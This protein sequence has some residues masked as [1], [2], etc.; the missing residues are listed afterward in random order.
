MMYTYWKWDKAI[1]KEYCELI[2][3]N[4]DWAQ[5]KSARIHFD[6]SIEDESI[7]KTKIVWEHNLSVVGCIADRYI[8]AANVAA[9]WNYDLEK[10]LN[11][12][13]I[14]EYDSGGF[15]DWHSDGPIIHEMP[16]KLSFSLLLS[17]PKDFE[18]GVFELKNIKE[19]LIMEQG[20]V[21]VF[22][23]SYPHRVTPVTSGSR[24]SAVAWMHGP[25]FK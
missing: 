8:R 12:I 19:P 20:S 2:V 22:I 3:K 4:A 1:S 18:G 23:S 17:D 13:Q 24:Y 6:N 16:R 11:K 5:K 9:G 15:Y 14:G 10:N 21:I 7:R 25:N